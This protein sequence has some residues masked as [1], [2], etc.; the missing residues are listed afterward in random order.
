MCSILGK[1]ESTGSRF[2]RILRTMRKGF[3]KRIQRKRDRQ[4]SGSQLIRNSLN[5]LVYK[6]NNNSNSSSCHQNL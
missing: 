2:Q 6:L 3:G 4:S 1:K 5:I